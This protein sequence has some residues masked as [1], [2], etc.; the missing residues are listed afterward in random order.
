LAKSDDAIWDRLE[1]FL[2]PLLLGADGS[3]GGD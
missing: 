1:E 3:A 2:P